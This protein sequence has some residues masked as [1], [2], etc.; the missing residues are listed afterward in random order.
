MKFKKTFCIEV[1][2]YNSYLNHSI[3]MSSR[4]TYQKSIL[5]PNQAWWF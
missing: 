2:L 4:T 3:D 1:I 5:A